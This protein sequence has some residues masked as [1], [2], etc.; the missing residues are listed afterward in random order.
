M[1]DQDHIVRSYDGEFSLLNGRIARMGGLVEMML[2]HAFD[3]LNAL[4]SELAEDTI[5]EDNSVDL[6]EKEIEEQAI[7][8]IARRQPMANDL[9]AIIGALKVATELER[10][11]DLG[12][13]IAKRVMAISDNGKA[14]LV[15]YSLDHMG[16]SALLQLN[17]VLDAYATGDADKA[18]KVWKQ[19]QDLDSLYNSIFREFLTYMM[20]DPRNIGLF[21]HLQFAA[22]NIE[23]IGD[24]TTNIAEICYFQVHGQQMDKERQKDDN[25]ST[26][27]LSNIKN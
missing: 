12:K 10:I 13:N 20:E 21:T 1:K 8:M 6:L 24:H 15:R 9:R 27:P 22:K 17:N 23:R 2:G 14:E 11:G 5:E 4:D 26:M 25:T 7:S 19:D 3:A 16:N 18:V